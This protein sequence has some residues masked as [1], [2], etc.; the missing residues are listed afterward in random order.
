[1]IKFSDRAG[2]PVEVSANPRKDNIFGC[3]VTKKTPN[4][5]KVI[6]FEMSPDSFIYEAIR[7]LNSKGINFEYTP[8]N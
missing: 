3:E 2:Q 8:N 7:M 4:E 6:N 5:H 1:M